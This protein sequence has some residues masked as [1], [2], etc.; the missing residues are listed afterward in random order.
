MLKELNWH[1]RTV[2]VFLI[3]VAL[4]AGIVGCIRWSCCMRWSGYPPDPPPSQN[5]E[6]RTWY[7]LDNVRDNM[8]GNHTLMNDLDSTTPGYGEL[9]SPTANQGKGWEPIEYS[10]PDGHLIG[11]VGTFDGQGYEIRDLFITRPDEDHVGLFSTVGEIYG[12]GV[13]KDIG[14]V[15][16]TVCGK[17][18]VGGLVGHNDGV[19]SNSYFTGSVTSEG[20]YVGGLVGINRATVSDSYFTGALT[21]DECVG[22]VVGWNSGGTVSGSNSTG[23][24]TGHSTV[25]GLVGDNGSFSTVS[26]SYSSSSVTG[27]GIVGGL[28]GHS[29]YAGT[30]S[31]CYFTGV[32]TGKEDVGGLVGFPVMNRT[33]HNSYYNYDEVPINGVSMITI[34]AL[35]GKDFDEWL[36][37]GKFLD[38]NERLSQENGYYAINNVTDFKELL[39][40][41]QH[42]TLKFR[43]TN[44]LNLATEP[45]LFIPYL[46]AEFHGNGHKIS[47]LKLNYDSVWPLGLFG[48]LAPGGRITD[49]GVENANTTGCSDVGALVGYI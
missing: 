28:V 17:D 37:N 47:N 45:N 4:I 14:L 16:A 39:A 21:G 18:R 19:V 5:L 25:G 1:A 35:F 6:I 9:A 36:A 8:D 48:Y 27:E 26:K 3:A 12:G 44:D 46:A 34:G 10:I 29:G 49:V 20:S 23:S 32:V 24:V 2:S 30:L 13:I 11:L 33:V 40:F 41:G 7:D 31:D 42:D 38:V 22:G 43:L 15:N